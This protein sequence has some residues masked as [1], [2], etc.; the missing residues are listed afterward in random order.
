MESCGFWGKKKLFMGIFYDYDR[1]F[2]MIY[3]SHIILFE[4]HNKK[5][6]LCCVCLEDR[7]YF[8]FAR[9]IEMFVLISEL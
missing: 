7:V 9:N 5:K 1:C 8:S 4:F 3:V 2:V 6:W